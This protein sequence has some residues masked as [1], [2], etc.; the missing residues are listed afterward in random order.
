MI[1][2]RVWFRVFVAHGGAAL[3]QPPPLL[4]FRRLFL[5]LAV[6][7]SL[8][9]IPGSLAY[10][11]FANFNSVLAGDEAAGMGGAHTA[12][13]GDS[14]ATAFYNPATMG[15]NG[16]HK[17]SASTRIYNKYSTEFGENQDFLTAGERLNTGFF[18]GV[19]S[20]AGSIFRYGQWSGGVS[21][22]VPD[23]DF[24]SGLVVNTDDQQTFLNTVDES[25]WAGGG[26]GYNINDKHSIGLSGYYTARRLIRTVTDRWTPAFDREV[27]TY[28]EKSVQSNSLV[29]VLGYFWMLSDRISFGLS[30]RPPSFNLD[31]QGVVQITKTD[32]DALPSEVLNV[33]DSR[34]ETHVPLKLALGTSISLSSRWLLAVDASFHGKRR[35][36][37]LAGSDGAD[38]YDHQNTWNFAVGVQYDLLRPKMT[39][40]GGFFTNRSSFPM[41]EPGLNLRQGDSVD[42]LGASFNTSF[43]M[44][45]H[46]QYTFG[47]FYTGGNGFSSQRLR[48]EFQNIS[49][50]SHQFSLQLSTSYHF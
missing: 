37:D 17:L 45:N 31:G 1:R 40:R 23:F 4:L 5:P 20:S 16:G 19:P 21:I 14:S 46:F 28:E 15:R 18:Q 36:Q 48:G 41:P 12:V 11:A 3:E 29:F 27:L 50:S 13:V 8:T 22:M 33:S 25:L 9:M 24:F 2:P 32:T 42:M 38:F 7:V 6:T 49:K 43:F 10:G 44:N 30:F 26:M 47:I 34:P 39:L 35:Y